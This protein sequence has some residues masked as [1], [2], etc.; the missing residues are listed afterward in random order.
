MRKFP[1]MTI[2]QCIQ[3]VAAHRLALEEERMRRLK[4]DPD[5][6][7]F[8]GEY[9]EH[10]SED[11]EAPDVPATPTPTTLAPDAAAGARPSTDDRLR[12]AADRR[13]RAE[14]SKQLNAELDTEI[15]ELRLEHA[16]EIQRE[17]IEVKRLAAHESLEDVAKA[18]VRHAEQE[19]AA[20]A[21]AAAEKALVARDSK[22]SLETAEISS[23]T[24]TAGTVVSPTDARH[25][26][27]TTRRASL[28][29][30]IEQEHQ[31]ETEILDMRQRLAEIRRR[32]AV[33][34][35]VSQLHR[36]SESVAIAQLRKELG[37]LLVQSEQRAALREHQIKEGIAD[38]L[39]M[40]YLAGIREKQ[41]LLRHELDG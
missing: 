6:G 16:L 39:R 36:H 11:E 14:A 40:D 13:A 28:D 41:R 3:A 18:R 19:A 23:T 5:L 12:A 22:L 33:Q 4:E 26:A 7:P 9:M 15:S 34:A 29:G 20:A 35:K 32:E 2:D 24:S 37:D 21:A 27:V 8:E 10:E 17:A 31:L 38:A 30:L 1:G 25:E